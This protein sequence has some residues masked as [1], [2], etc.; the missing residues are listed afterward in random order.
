MAQVP[1]PDGVTPNGPGPDDASP[2]ACLIESDTRRNYPIH[3]S[4]FTFG[5]SL[6][7][8]LSAASLCVSRRHGEIIRSSEGYQVRDTGSSN[9]TFVGGKRIE[10]AVELKDGDVIQVPSPVERRAQTWSVT[11]KLNP[12]AT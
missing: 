7:N 9:G 5:R 3:R 12:A 10:G 4:P 2:P 8:D 11:F 1:K 6:K